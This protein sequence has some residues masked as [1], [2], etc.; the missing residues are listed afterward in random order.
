LNS[1]RAIKPSPIHHG[2]RASIVTLRKET[3]GNSGC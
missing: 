3:D 2:S 1:I